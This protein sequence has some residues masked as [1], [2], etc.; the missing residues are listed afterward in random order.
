MACA[1]IGRF[2]SYQD[3]RYSLTGVIAGCCSDMYGYVCF[4][5]VSSDRFHCV[6]ILV[7]SDRTWWQERD[8]GRHGAMIGLRIASM[9]RSKLLL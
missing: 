1:A 3:D 9:F 2:A 6:Y 4:V 7:L 8:C 5:I